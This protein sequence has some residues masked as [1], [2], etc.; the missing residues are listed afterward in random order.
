MA[1]SA[2]T[3]HRPAALHGVLRKPAAALKA[4]ETFKIQDLLPPLTAAEYK[5]R[6]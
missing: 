2:R 5:G 4:L 6:G 1:A 3:G